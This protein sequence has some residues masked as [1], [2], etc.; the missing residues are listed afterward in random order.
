ME[1]QLT[2]WSSRF[3]SDGLLTS[4]IKISFTACACGVSEPRADMLSDSG[5]LIEGVVIRAIQPFAALQN[6]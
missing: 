3:S 6:K 5:R 1:Y 2:S 4:D